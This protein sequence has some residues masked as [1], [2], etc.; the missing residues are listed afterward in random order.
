ME[1]RIRGFVVFEVMESDKI[2]KGRGLA[3]GGSRDKYRGVKEPW[4]DRKARGA[5]PGS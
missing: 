5:L 4:R 2:T 3:L 1:V